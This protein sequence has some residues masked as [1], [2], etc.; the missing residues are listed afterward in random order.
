M[1]KKLL[2]VLFGAFILFSSQVKAQTDLSQF[3]ISAYD[4]ARIILSNGRNLLL[5]NI[6]N[7]EG[8]KNIEV[9]KNINELVDTNNYIALFIDEEQIV[10][11]LTGDKTFFLNSLKEKNWMVSRELPPAD[12]LFDNCFQFLNDSI[13]AWKTLIDSLNLSDDEHAVYQLYLSQLGLGLE[14]TEARRMAK[15]YIKAYPVSV[16]TPFAKSLNADFSTGSMGYALG[17]GNIY[18]SES[19]K[20]FVDIS[21]LMSF[22][23]DYFINNFYWSFYMQASLKGA[24]QNGMEG[25]DE[26]GDIH[27]Y[28]KGNYASH[29]SFGIKWGAQLYKNK[30]MRVYPFCTTSVANLSV[31]HTNNDIDNL[32]IST[33]FGLGAGLGTDIALFSW[34]G[35]SLEEGTMVKHHIGLRLNAGFETIMAGKDNV[36]YSNYFLHAG[37]VW[38]MGD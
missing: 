16:Y 6:K 23:M 14:K 35:S 36:D 11:F 5:Q 26:F 18:L 29:F 30:W 3:A 27:F 21:G 12:N 15:K 7:G 10:S 1:K 32:S 25:V 31:S 2:I 33:G 38:W 22:E 34:T 19:A 37:I 28:D 17:F 24:S 20:S 13:D 4:S 8:V 9:L